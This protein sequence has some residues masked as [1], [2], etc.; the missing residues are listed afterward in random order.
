[1]EEYTFNMA[2]TRY[3]S[4]TFSALNGIKWN[5]SANDG[6]WFNTDNWDTGNLPQSGDDVV[7]LSSASVLTDLSLNL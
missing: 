4:A 2:H 7:I 3:I 1:M 5:G 6:N